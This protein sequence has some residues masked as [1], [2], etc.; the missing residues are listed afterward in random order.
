VDEEGFYRTR[1]DLLVLAARER[2]IDA[3]R[4]EWIASP[5]V[6]EAA[7]LPWTPE[8]DDVMLRR[9]IDVL[10]AIVCNSGAVAGSWLEWTQN[11]TYIPWTPAEYE[12]RLEQLVVLAV[13]RMKLA[14]IRHECD[15]RT[16]AYAAALEHLS[17]VYELRGIFP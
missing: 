9:G 5:I 3:Q 7:N 17:R 10:P 8:G 13:R 16:A 6:A 2:M 1:T 11:R 12:E 15:W 14:A 4:A